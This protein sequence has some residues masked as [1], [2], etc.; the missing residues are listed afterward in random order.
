VQ[1][2]LM[3]DAR[4]RLLVVRHGTVDHLLVVSPGG[5]SLLESRPA[6]TIGAAGPA[7]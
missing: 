5:A 4:T 2:A 1:A 7:R 3:L 6:P